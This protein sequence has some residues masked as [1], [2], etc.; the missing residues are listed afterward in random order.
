MMRPMLEQMMSS[1]GGTPS[2]MDPFGS[3]RHV[4]RLMQ[5][6]EVR[7]SQS[8]SHISDSTSGVGVGPH[9]AAPGT[10]LNLEPVTLEKS[11]LV[12]AEGNA[13]SIQV[14]SKKLMAVASEEEKPIFEE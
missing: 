11:C 14:F 9:L 10:Y 8:S 3:A 6:D 2:N 12:S 4:E 1:V 13:A 7:R 5:Q